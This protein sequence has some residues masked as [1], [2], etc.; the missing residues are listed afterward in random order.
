MVLWYQI[1]RKDYTKLTQIDASPFRAQTTWMLMHQIEELKNSLPGNHQ[2]NKLN[3]STNKQPFHRT[4]CLDILSLCVCARVCFKTV[5]AKILLVCQVFIFKRFLKTSL[6]IL[7]TDYCFTFVFS[8]CLW[9]RRIC[10]KQCSLD[11]C[12]V[13]LSFLF[14]D[15]LLGVLLVNFYIEC[16]FF[17]TCIFV[18]LHTVRGFREFLQI[19]H[20]FSVYLQWGLSIRLPFFFF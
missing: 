1:W 12:K 7:I 17:V 5:S 8:H 13:N 15:K 9:S 4:L 2:Q 19:I 18:P 10:W 14:C 6:M 3:Q 11:E 20:V 16:G